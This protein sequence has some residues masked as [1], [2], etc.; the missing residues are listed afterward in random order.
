MWHNFTAD[1]IIPVIWNLLVFVHM[2]LFSIFHSLLLLV[3]NTDYFFPPTASYS[4][5]TSFSWPPKSPKKVLAITSFYCWIKLPYW[6]ASLS[7]LKSIRQS[8]PLHDPLSALYKGH[9]IISILSPWSSH[10]SIHQNTVKSSF[11]CATPSWELIQS[12][13]HQL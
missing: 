12:I 10:C 2:W 4:F 8:T 13:E 7:A 5:F 9:Q 1:V 11:L 3:P 6:L